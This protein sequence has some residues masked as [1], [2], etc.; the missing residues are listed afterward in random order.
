ME[1]AAAQ[2]LL[3][4]LPEDLRDTYRGILLPE[5][6]ENADQEAYLCRLVK[7]ADKLS[8][9]IKCVEE[10]NAGNGEFRTAKQT[11]QASVDEMA[12]QMPEVSDFCRDFLL[13]Y[14]STLDELL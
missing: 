10:E 2:R 11:I 5:K 3:L 14:G 13:A 4:L 9:L 6:S 7:A 8:A 1:D 12:S